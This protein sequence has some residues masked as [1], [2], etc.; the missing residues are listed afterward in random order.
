MLIHILH[1]MVRSTLLQLA[2]GRQIAQVP[3]CHIWISHAR[4]QHV[5]FDYHIIIWYQQ[6]KCHLGKPEQHVRSQW[7]LLDQSRSQNR[8]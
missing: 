3:M 1:N 2:G 6:L 7:I 4:F 8:P 5:F